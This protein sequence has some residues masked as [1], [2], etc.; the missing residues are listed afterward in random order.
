MWASQVKGGDPAV[1]VK[2]RVSTSYGVLFMHLAEFSDG[3]RTV[4]ADGR[5]KE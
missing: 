3:Q 4:V 5:E 2:I 1:P